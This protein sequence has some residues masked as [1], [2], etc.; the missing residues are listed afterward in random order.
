[1]LKLPRFYEI[2]PSDFNTKNIRRS[3]SYGKPQ[4][5]LTGLFNNFKIVALFKEKSSRSIC[6]TGI[7]NKI[8]FYFNQGLQI[9]DNT[10]SNVKWDILFIVN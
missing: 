9:I 7:D 10:V 6:E 3:S 4:D 5:F 8:G 1:M 2:D